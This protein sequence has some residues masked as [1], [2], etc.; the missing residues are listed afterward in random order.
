MEECTTTIVNSTYQ[1]LL[2][3]HG[4]TANATDMA[5]CVLLSAHLKG[6]GVSTRTVSIPQLALAL[7]TTIT[8]VLQSQDVFDVNSPLKLEFQL[9][10]NSNR[11]HSSIRFRR[12]QVEDYLTK[13]SLVTWI[14]NSTTPRVCAC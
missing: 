5:R 9:Q 6:R 14:R 10:L 7:Q 1:F 2:T 4:I 3:T 11:G 12:L 8:N 13:P